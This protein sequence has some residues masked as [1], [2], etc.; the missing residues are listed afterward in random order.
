MIDIEKAI[1]LSTSKSSGP[2]EL[3][4]TIIEL[5]F[6]VIS[7]PLLHL[8]N[9]SI[10]SCTY[11]AIW[12]DA[13]IL[14]IPKCPNP[15]EVSHYRPIAL[16]CFLSKILEKIVARRMVNFLE[17][18]EKLDFLQSG[19]RWGMST[20]T[21]LLKLI[22]DVKRAI[23]SKKVTALVLFDYTK[24]F[25]MV[26]H[27]ILLQKL[28][29]LG[30]SESTCSWIKSYLTGRRQCVL[31]DSGTRSDWTPV[32][33]GVPQGTIFGPLFFICYAHDLGSNS[34]VP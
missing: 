27:T 17:L 25:D 11:P 21:A 5:A 30:F 20:A 14:P 7:F 19:F 24:A 1:K 15:K 33:R 16:T 8:Y 23:D 2:D 29:G 13:L 34:N 9:F 10:R 6:P 31:G 28:S 4:S 22:D 32:T 26:D 3:S 12:K 18:F